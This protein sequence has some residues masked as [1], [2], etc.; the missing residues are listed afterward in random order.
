MKPGLPWWFFDSLNGMAHFF[1]QV[2]ETT[3]IYDAA[4]FNDGTR[5]FPS[6]PVRHDIWRRAS[7]SW[8]AG[9]VV[10]G[11]ID[12]NDAGGMAHALSHDLA[13]RAY[14]LR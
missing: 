5:A 2:V 1:D 6:I 8:L 13:K 7:V 10:R 9:L 14:K 11:I 12:M 4:G 3:G